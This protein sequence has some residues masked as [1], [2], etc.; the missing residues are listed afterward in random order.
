M[1][2]EP[3][4]EL[5]KVT[6]H[7]PLLSLDKTQSISDLKHFIGNKDFLLM[8][9]LDGLT[10]RLDY[11]NGRLVVAATRGDGDKGEDILHNALAMLNVPMEIPYK[12]RLSVTG[13]AFIETHR[14]DMINAKL[15]KD[16]QFST[17]RNLAAGSVKAYDPEI[18]KKR[19]VQFNAFNVLEG[20]DEINSRNL[21]LQKLEEFGFDVCPNRLL[22]ADITEEELS[23]LLKNIKQKSAEECIPID[24]AVVR[25]DDIAYSKS[26]GRTGHHYKDGIAFKYDDEKVETVLRKVEWTTSRNGSI[27][28]VAIFDTVMMDGCAV[29]RATLHNLS[30]IKG[31]ELNIGDRILISK[32]H[33]IIPAVEG[34]L[35][36]DTG[37]MNFPDRCPCCGAKTV[38]KVTSNAKSK[39]KVEKLFCTNPDCGSSLIK[40]FVH[41]IDKDSMN[42]EGMAESTISRF[43]EE[44]S[45]RIFRICTTYQ[46]TRTKLWHLTDLV[47]N[48]MKRLSVRL[49]KARMSLLISF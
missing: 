17:V 20:M 32:R 13:E 45:F 14:F 2:Y 31:L 40:Q 19:F 21:R 7:I 30:F 12:N 25:F 26:L 6:H 47:R 16:K 18:C 23:E 4:S 3:V 10:V 22:S 46:D 43:I 29:S 33:M 41:F 35:D 38:I 8:Y 5:K 44:A 1:G 37:I 34:N 36:R 39:K 48:R 11:E 9:K 27:S 15:P 49:K 42:I 28:P 24:G